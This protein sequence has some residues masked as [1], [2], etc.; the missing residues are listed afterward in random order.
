M[1]SA[2]RWLA[3]A[4]CVAGL[5]MGPFQRTFED[6][7]RYGYLTDIM[8]SDWRATNV[9]LDS[10]DCTVSRGAWLAVCENDRLIPISERAIADDPGHALLLSAWAAVTG[11]RATLVDV[12]RLNALL[13]LVGLVALA[14]LLF[15]LR[16]WITSLVLLALG[17]AEFLGWMGTSPHWAF[18]GMVSLAGL[19]PL[20]IATRRN[21]AWIAGGIV[22]LALATLV[23]ES[24]GL[25][26]FA[27]TLI[28]VAAT[29]LRAPRSLRAVPRLGL[30]LVLATGALLAPKW[31]TMARDAALPMAPAE[32]LQTHG[33]SHTL[34]LGL[35]FVENKWGIRYDDDYGE[36]LANKAGLVFCS[37][38]YFR[39]MWRLYL[40]R[41]AEDP[42]E[43]A[44]LYWEKAVRLLSVPTL[45][46]G[47][48]FG[49]VLAIGLAHLLAAAWFGAWRRV[50][51]PEGL[52]IE[53]VS[54][55]FLGLFLAQAI[56]ALPSQMYAVPVNAFILVLFGALVE[57]AARGL[58]T[59]AAR[60]RRAT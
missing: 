17:P 22:A 43:V 2:L 16:A 23:R 19:L 30:V 60:Y 25:M 58:W 41:I 18:I 6:V 29:A 56:L 35:G 34:Y 45:Q 50:G 31:V 33:L 7:R 12:A 4:F 26:G 39:M 32:R 46:P 15:S 20:A 11:E 44:R 28:A 36:D 21:A 1:A 57:F 54:L 51:L 53:A 40:G 24:I 9:W 55:A 48:P 3:F 38:E 47:P 49:L 52:E 27:L 5:V 8:P 42:L 37:P 59:L 13:N 10:T 14:A